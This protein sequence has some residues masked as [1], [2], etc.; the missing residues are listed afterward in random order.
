MRKSISTRV[1]TSEKSC[2]KKFDWLLPAAAEEVAIHR[3]DLGNVVSGGGGVRAPQQHVRRQL[4]ARNRNLGRQMHPQHAQH[5][6][7]AAAPTLL[8]FFFFFNNIITFTLDT[9]ISAACTTL[10][11]RGILTPPAAQNLHPSPLPLLHPNP[12]LHILLRHDEHQPLAHP[13]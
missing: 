6:E 8:C 3:G 12:H 1:V 2:I 5:P 4:A 7:P 11:I 10:A 9:T 13:P